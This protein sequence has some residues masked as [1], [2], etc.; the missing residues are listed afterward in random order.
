[1]DA[2]NIT[3]RPA[4]KEDC[5]AI[6]AL[7]NEL[8]VFE[9]AADEVTVQ[10][11]HFV[12]S[13]FGPQPVW[14]SLVAE[15]DEKIVGIALYYIRYSTWKG[16]RLYLED[17]IVSEQYRQLGIGSSLMDEIVRIAKEKN[18][19]GIMW[20]VLDWNEPAIQ[21]YKKYDAKFDGEWVN[22]NIDL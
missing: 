16:Q 6:M 12:K 7:I 14:W 17:I 4:T 15:T 3:I 19:S 18:F 13:G 21:F 1:M 10:Y 22:C 2:V 9:R 8:A 11:D 5:P 20:Q